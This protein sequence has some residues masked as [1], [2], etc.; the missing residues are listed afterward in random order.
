MRRA[1]LLALAAACA[2]PALADE[3]IPSR[4][5]GV[6][7]SDDPL[8]AEGPIQGEFHLQEDGFG[9]LIGASP[10][11]I[12]NS[13]PNKGQPGPRITMGIPFRARLEGETLTILPF[14]PGNPND[15]GPTLECRYEEGGLTLRCA[16]PDRSALL[17]KRR[18][19]TLDPRMTE[20]IDG[21]RI[22]LRAYAG[23]ASALRPAPSTRP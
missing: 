17:M 22:A 1:L 21:M 5:T 23:K 13:G 8:F 15:K 2:L 4:L 7:G 3:R 20:A 19:A 10:P 9:V 18:S 11:M 6:W 14:N 12:Q 16:M